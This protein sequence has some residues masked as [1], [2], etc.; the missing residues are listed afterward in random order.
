MASTISASFVQQWNEEVHVLFQQ[1]P[2]KLR[3]TV[4]TING[5]VGSV[6]NFPRI[7]A[8]T[9][10]TKPR[11]GNLT[12]IDPTIDSVAM[13][14]TDSYA[15]IYLDKLDEVKTNANLRQSFQIET[16]A[17]INRAMDSQI[18]TALA[19][20]SNT[21]AT[22]TGGFTFQK[23]QDALQ[24]MNASE[25]DPDDRFL[26]IGAKQISE[27]LGI[28]N[29]TNSQY[30]AVEAILHAGIGNAMGFN[31]RMSTLLPNTG[32][33]GAHTSGSTT[34]CFA[35]SKKAVGMA[36][37]QDVTTQVDWIPQMQSTQVVTSM[38]VGAGKIDDLGLV[39][40]PC[41]E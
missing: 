31:F 21:I 39:N 10:N 41:V 14:L 22:T 12:G 33:T 16:V 2:S 40:I 20:A 8:I 7:A 3:D 36:I 37:G 19:T 32:G 13:T 4:T 1:K 11:N 5:V 15:T 34:K 6:Y 18:I 30:L 28:Q 24:Y 26:V 9:A 23:L 25:V 17:A 27:A 35:Y 29:L 38:S